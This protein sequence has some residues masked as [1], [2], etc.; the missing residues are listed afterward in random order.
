[1]PSDHGEYAYKHELEFISGLGT[2]S[3]HR[4]DKDELLMSYLK[5]CEKRANWISIKRENVFAAI[6]R[7]LANV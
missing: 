5:A 7:E 2:W 6:R 3:E 1:M 4:Y